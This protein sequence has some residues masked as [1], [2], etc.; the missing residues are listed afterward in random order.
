M[1]MGFKDVSPENRLKL[2]EIRSQLIRD[3]VFKNELYIESK[4]LMNELYKVGLLD[5]IDLNFQNKKVAAK[6]DYLQAIIAR[7]KLEG[8]NPENENRIIIEEFDKARERIEKERSGGIKIRTT[9][10]KN[11]RRRKLLQKV[12]NQTATAEDKD[13]L[14]RI[15]EGR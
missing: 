1:I 13:E 11:V 6:W 14:R 5:K 8:K 2:L 4:K 3:P 10:E 15:N 7:R 12:L 9:D